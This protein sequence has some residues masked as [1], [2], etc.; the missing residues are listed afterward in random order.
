MK[1]WQRRSCREIV[2]WA[3]SQ[4]LDT[5]KLVANGNVHYCERDVSRR[6]PENPRTESRSVGT[7][8]L[9]L[10]QVSKPDSGQT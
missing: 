3:T 2:A 4:S 10:V 1:S 5:T 9:A 7:L 6:L 8:R